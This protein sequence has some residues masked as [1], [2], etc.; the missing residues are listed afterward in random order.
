MS[1]VKQNE[2]SFRDPANRVFSFNRDIYR[3]IFA[4]GVQD[5]TSAKSKGVYA[6]LSEAG[7]LVPHQE[8]SI[9]P[10]A[11]E[12]TV[13][14]LRHVSLPMVSYPW[15]WSYTMLK[16]AALL[17]LD[18]MEIL[19]PQ[20]FWLRD[21]SALNVQYDGKGL[22][23]IDTLSIGLRKKN[24]PWIAYRQ[25][26][27][28]FLAPLALA[29]Y[30]D[31]RTL[32]LWREYID[33]Y[34]LDLAIRMISF[35]KRYLSRLF[36]HLTLHARFQ[37]K[38]QGNDQKGDYKAPI[39]SDASLLGLIRSLRRTVSSLR[40]KPHSSVWR[41]YQPGQNYGDNVLNLKKQNVDR[42]V[43]RLK[44]ATVWDLGGNTGEFSSIAA[45]HGS[46]VV[47]IDADPACTDHLYQ[48]LKG[49]LQG[50]SIL[51][52][53]MNLA[54]PSPAL[55]W[56]EKERY[57]LRDR[58]PADLVMALALVHHLVFSHNI[59]L[60]SIAEWLSSIGNHV[61]IE[62]ISKNDPMVS[63][64]LKARGNEHLPYSQDLFESSFAHHFSLL[65]KMELNSSRSLYLYA[66]KQI[67][68]ETNSSTDH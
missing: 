52:L 64:L 61:V 1:L 68:Y 31:I 47:S 51:P 65:E 8:I 56:N 13:Y 30:K 7:I 59:P 9:P 36:I 21:G 2:G 15:E 24:H 25:F 23:L 27:S 35:R 57:G 6:R 34:P 43:G 3:A 53:T 4:A 45:S 38:G 46:F 66:K 60:P 62:Y 29:A 17:H 11:P 18:A 5:Y 16:E 55:G 44:P 41:Q 22:R 33:G 14:C 40:W 19:V 42:I 37:Q 20:G 10:A 63:L 12:E 28:H 32:A 67:A 54:N 58:G 50:K 39:F 49:D 48:R 26:C